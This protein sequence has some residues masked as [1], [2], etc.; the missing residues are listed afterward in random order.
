VSL[1]SL[2]PLE[3]QVAL[4][5][6]AGRGLG[7]AIARTLARDG[8]TVV[9]GDVRDEEGAAVA[10]ELARQGA[11][12][13]F[14]HLDVT[15]DASWIAAMAEISAVFGRL[16]VLVNNA[17]ILR[18][19]TIAGADFGDWSDVLAVN[20]SGPFLGMKHAAPLL[21]AQGG[22]IVNVGSVAGLGGHYDPAYAASK[23]GLRGLSKVAALEFVDDGIRVNAVH[24][25]L[26]A[27]PLVETASER[28]RQSSRDLIPMGREVEPEEVAEVVAFLASDRAGFVTGADLAVDGGYTAGA[29][30]KARE[31]Y[32]A[33]EGSA[34]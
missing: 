25:A 22:S 27:T 2:P 28:H 16:D 26:M 5:S 1:N 31:R 18:R 13:R 9:L 12:A 32:K 24:P 15:D 17:G 29:A 34:E 4:V 33:M 21:R 7:A 6:G 30:V 3:G 11:R 8:A 19:T 23:W 20:L 10:S 14:L